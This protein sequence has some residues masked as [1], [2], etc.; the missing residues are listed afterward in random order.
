[1]P[2]ID[3]NPPRIEILEQDEYPDHENP[4][5]FIKSQGDDLRR[6]QFKEVN[7]NRAGGHKISLGSSGT[8]LFLL[9][10]SEAEFTAGNLPERHSDLLD[11]IDESPEISLTTDEVDEVDWVTDDRLSNP[12]YGLFSILLEYSRRTRFIT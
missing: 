1:M 4:T 5:L 2:A 9:P 8:G 3:N 10:L 12:T 7:P 11:R 6:G